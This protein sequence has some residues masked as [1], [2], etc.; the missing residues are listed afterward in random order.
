MDLLSPK[1]GSTAGEAPV[2]LAPAL[3]G[4]TVSRAEVAGDAQLAAA[5]RWTAGAPATHGRARGSRCVHAQS[6]ARC[7]A[8]TGTEPLAL[9]SRARRSGTDADAHADGK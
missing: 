7:A 6:G 5:E 2:S 4:L 3:L 1:A 9:A 8:V